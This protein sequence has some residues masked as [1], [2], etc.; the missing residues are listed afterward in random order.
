MQ[1]VDK[2]G[3]TFGQGHLVITTKSGKSK[4]PVVTVAW[5]NIT[6]VLANQTDLQDA[7]NLKVP[8]S[9]TLTINGVTQDLSANRTW[10]ISTGLTIGTTPISLGAIGRVL[11]EGAGNV[12]QESAN[13]LWDNTNARLELI[14]ADNVFGVLLKTA[15]GQVRIKPYLNPAY[16]ALFE[17]K[18]ISDTSYLP[19]TISGSKILLAD[20]NVLINTTTDAGYKL[21]V[22]GSARIT[23]TFVLGGEFFGPNNTYLN[24]PTI[25]TGT[26][27]LRFASVNSY[28]NFTATGTVQGNNILANSGNAEVKALGTSIP[29]LVVQNTTTSATWRIESHRTTS[30]A[31]EF[32]NDITNPVLNLFSTRNVGIG[33]FTDA[34]YRLDVNGTVRNLSTHQIYRDNQIG[35]IDLNLYNGQAGWQG[36]MHYY[37]GSGGSGQR[38]T[39]YS[40]GVIGTND[41]MSIFSS[42]NVGINTTTDAGFKLDVN[43]TFR[44]QSNATIV[45]SMTA[46]TLVKSGGNSTQ[47][48]MADGSVVNGGTSTGVVRYGDYINQVTFSGRT[49]TLSPSTIKDLLWG[50]L[51]IRYTVTDTYTGSYPAAGSTWVRTYTL[52]DGTSATYS[53]G[54]IYMGFWVN[55]PPANITVRVQNTSGTWYGPYSGSNVGVGGTF[56]YWKIPCGGPNY[57]KTWEVTLTP[58]DGLSINLQTVNI[59][60]DNTEGIDQ[61]PLVGRG[62]SSIYGNLSFIGTGAATNAYITN[63]GVLGGLYL[64]VANN[65]GIIEFQNSGGTKAGSMFMDGTIWRFKS[66]NG[67]D[68]LNIFAN[69][70]LGIKQTTD[71]GF[72]LDVNGTA[73][74]QGLTTLRTLA[75]SYNSVLTVEN[76]GSATVDNKNVAMF[77]GARGNASNIDDNTNLGIWQ[78]SNI[79]NNYAVLNYYNSVGYLTAFIGAQLLSHTTSQSG[80]LIFGNSSSGTVS[81]KMTLFSTGN[82]AINTTTDAGF[83]LDVNG[84]ARVTTLRSDNPVIGFAPSTAGVL[85]GSNQTYRI[86][87]DGSSYYDFRTSTGIIYRLRD[88]GSTSFGST[89]I[90]ASAMVDIQ[91]TTKGFL[92]PRMTNAQMLAIGTPAEGLI[93]YDTTNRKLCCYDGATWQPLF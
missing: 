3:N 91:S 27:W 2:Y 14:T 20:G 18:N 9:R 84:S 15:T 44:S 1:V 90:A 68:T 7:L 16:G 70:N 31:L 71:A 78:K 30:G 54:N 52:I 76:T 87:C 65:S 66:N 57:I 72:T 19:F 51:N 92:P 50:G 41:R 56:Q 24:G 28:G 80:N 37:T 45:G 12:V 39:F 83:K 53:S 8:T 4:L 55:Y 75:S 43:G 6:G 63:G 42:G 38:L 67:S 10:T 36:G 46:T 13:F 62:G 33:T 64:R 79:V 26:L 93:V 73:R 21:D 82:L 60:V 77:I 81:T 49:V 59:I 61:A 58:Q 69:G 40:G 88:D 47:Y 23:S 29:S 22:N 34:G 11:F 74:V 48:L 86:I 35:S 32:K 5:G 25:H 89:T 85:I 17:S